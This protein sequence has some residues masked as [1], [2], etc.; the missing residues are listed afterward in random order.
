M[1]RR[2]GETSA[3]AGVTRRILMTV[4]AIAATVSFAGLLV[5]ATPNDRGQKVV[6]VKATSAR[7]RST[8]ATKVA[9]GPAA[10]VKSPGA[11]RSSAHARVVASPDDVP[12]NDD[13]SSATDIPADG[14]FPLLMPA[15]DI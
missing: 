11:A 12:A 15:V 8:L 3:M 6:E 13:C 14:P 5:A 4:P 9:D 7:T 2:V 10:P 1:S